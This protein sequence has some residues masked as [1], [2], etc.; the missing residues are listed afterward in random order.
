MCPQ[1]ICRKLN[2]TGEAGTGTIQRSFQPP[3]CW[4]PWAHLGARVSRRAAGAPVAEQYGAPLLGL[5]GQGLQF[6]P[7]KPRPS[8]G[9]TE[10]LQ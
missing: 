3:E 7:Q 8:Q 6:S 10:F 2:K 1:E 9:I 5:L 4:G